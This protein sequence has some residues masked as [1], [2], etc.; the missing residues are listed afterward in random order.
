LVV[1]KPFLRQRERG[2]ESGGD[3][4][5][6]KQITER[7]ALCCRSNLQPSRIL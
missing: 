3:L 1:S 5:S 6:A 4:I 2:S 7:Y